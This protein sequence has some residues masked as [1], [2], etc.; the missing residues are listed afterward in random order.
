[1]TH[2]VRD[3]SWTDT[4]RGR[5]ADAGLRIGAASGHQDHW[6]GSHPTLPKAGAQPPDEEP[7]GISPA[8]HRD[9][10]DDAAAGVG[11]RSHHGPSG[12]DVQEANA[13]E[14]VDVP[15]EHHSARPADPV[16]GGQRRR[17]SPAPVRR[18]RAPASWRAPP[19][20][21]CWRRRILALAL[22]RG[23]GRARPLAR[24]HRDPGAH[25]LPR[26]GRTG[27]RHAAALPRR[28]TRWTP[29]GWCCRSR[30]RRRC[31]SRC[32]TRRPPEE[33]RP[34]HEDAA[35]DPRTRDGRPSGRPAYFP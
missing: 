23:D 32:S 1:M 16:R 28:A 24:P 21:R 15:E 33:P 13:R 22:R 26:P 5:R 20:A 10:T 11:R 31:S 12:D 34:P 14:D 18:H 30:W 35:R 8:D 9:V 4:L 6:H 27:D 17:R 7:P 19:P 25:R 29:R 2:G 3:T